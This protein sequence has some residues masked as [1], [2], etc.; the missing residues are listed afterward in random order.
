MHRYPLTPDEIKALR[1]FAVA[2]GRNWK[3]A[4]RQAWEHGSEPGIL[5]VLRNSARFGPA[6][7]ISFRVG[8]KEV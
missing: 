2:N 8:N 7:L 3:Q 6:G 5:Q 4:L 1:T